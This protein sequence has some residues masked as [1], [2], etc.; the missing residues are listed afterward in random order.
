MFYTKVLSS[1]GE[2][3]EAKRLLYQIYIQELNWRFPIHNPSGLIVLSKSGIKYL[4][5]KFDSASTWFG[6][7]ERELLVGCIRSVRRHKNSF[8][9]E[10]YHTLPEFLT[11]DAE[12]VETNRL[13]ILPAFRGSNAIYELSSFAIEYEYSRG[14][15]YSFTTAPLP[16]IGYFYIRKLGYKR[17]KL[18][19]FKYHPTDENTVT[20]M[21]LDASQPSQFKKIIS[22]M[23]SRSV[24]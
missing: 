4:H 23:K 14:I 12:V 24:V 13:A 2:I 21:Y 22:R 7:Y 10:Q 18:A 15:R 19:P 1:P 9:L 20:L 5:D 3:M 11:Q 17:V 6:V 8:E 16:G